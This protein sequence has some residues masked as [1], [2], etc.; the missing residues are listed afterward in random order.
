MSLYPTS[1]LTSSLSRSCGNAVKKAL[2]QSTETGKC[3]HTSLIW[4]AASSNTSLVPQL[5]MYLNSTCQAGC[6]NVTV[7]QFT[8]AALESCQEDFIKWNITNETVTTVMQHYPLIREIAC[9]KTSV[10]FDGTIPGVNLTSN[11][12]QPS[13]NATASAIPGATSGVQSASSAEQSPAIP[14]DA[15][16]SS[17]PAS[18]IA[19]RQESTTSIA[20]GEPNPNGN[21]STVAPTATPSAGG[22]GTNST[23]GTV[24]T[25]ST[26]NATYCLTKL[27]SELETYMGNLTFPYVV[28]LAFGGNE[29]AL[30]RLKS[31]PPAALCQ[32]CIGAAYDLVSQSPAAEQINSWVIGTNSTNGSNSTTSST[33]PV[34]N[35]SAN[36]T[37]SS[38]TPINGTTPSNDTIPANGTVGNNSTSGNNVTLPSLFNNTCNFQPSTD[39]KLPQV[40]WPTAQ[41]STYGHNITFWNE[42]TSA[43]QTQVPQNLTSPITN[44]TTEGGNSTEGSTPSQSSSA[45][46]SSS[47]DAGVGGAPSQSA[48]AIPSSSAA[49]PSPSETA[50]APTDPAASA[51]A[52]DT[53]P[54]SGPVQRNY[55]RLYQKF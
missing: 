34:N 17:T 46:P 2:N 33:S 6:S 26:S 23:N 45:V 36:A 8:G 12:T 50:A 48:G 4:A 47:G 43:W 16:A 10:P 19:R 25:N 39:G 5:D 55:R 14:T 28:N 30:D 24:P 18:A 31:I 20:P 41:N 51:S 54:Q 9:L 35:S 7:S 37:D 27:A 38:T 49:V 11:S 44:G 13:D 22:T 21:S 40:F 15:A 29:T 52:T 1:K 32:D 42:S 53:V 3:L